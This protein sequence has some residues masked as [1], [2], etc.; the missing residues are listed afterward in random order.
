MKKR[1]V[2][3]LIP[4]HNEEE[5]I[6]HV[7]RGIPVAELAQMGLDAEVIVIDNN[8]S[9]G[10]AEISRSLGAQVIFE[11]KEGKGNAI[12][13]GF[14]SLSS[15][16]SFVVMLD[17]DNTYKPAEIP[18][19]IE[20][21]VSG[22]WD[23]VVGS[24]L[25]GEAVKEALKFQNR[26]A[27]NVF[28]FLART[29]YSTN[30]SDVLSGFAAWKKEAVDMLRPHL[31][32]EG[33]GIEMEMITK[34]ARLDF[35]MRSIPI[36]YDIRKGRSKIHAI[37]DGILILHTCAKNIFWAPK[38]IAGVSVPRTS[39]SPFPC[40]PKVSIVIPALNE[41][42][43]IGATISQIP[44]DELARLGYSF[45][46][47]VVD[48]G[49]TDRTAEI[50]REA[51]A[52]VVYQPIPGYGSAY[53][54]GF[55][56]ATGD[57]IATGDADMTY[58]FDALPGILETMRKGGFDFITTDR[59]TYLNPK[60]MTTL[61]IF[62]NWLLSAVARTL[63]GLPFRDS[64]SG[65]WIFKRSILKEINLRSNGMAFSQEIKTETYMKGF[66]C[67]EVPIE[68]RERIGKVKLDTMR[69]GIGNILQL[70]SKRF[71]YAK[72]VLNS[73]STRQLDYS[74]GTRA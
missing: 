23:V 31:T 62:G 72:R 51:G 4:C 64:Q 2:A 50:S 57:I 49:S 55:A 68:Y 32:S 11:S 20:L 7:I 44:T 42:S 14:N 27:N 45:E 63:F 10:T 65:M 21:M 17:G 47:I 13:A 66:R 59:L 9:D 61:H 26:I 39:L 58:P 54:A 28:T 60:A 30:I 5:G 3:V 46:I 48:N 1:K 36:V 22:E 52:K 70:F 8:S 40:A 25:D 56:N 41:E 74:D 71:S 37:R 69:D 19:F 15:D 53:K 43:A 73:F 35:R 29:L 67:I 18:R 12:R 6:A 16:T 38:S 33:F 24:R 34:M